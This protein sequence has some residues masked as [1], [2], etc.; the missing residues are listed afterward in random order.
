M[1]LRRRGHTRALRRRYGRSYTAKPLAFPSVKSFGE[2]FTHAQRW[3]SADLNARGTR[4]ARGGR[5]A[6]TV[7]GYLTLSG[8]G[9]RESMKVTPSAKVLSYL[10]ENMLALKDSLYFEVHLRDDGA[11]VVAKHNK[12]IGDRWLAM[13]DSSTIPSFELRAVD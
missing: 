3:S 5:E 13:I 8:Q 1:T 12:I 6:N 4:L 10:S 7:S 2:L 9:R 11:L